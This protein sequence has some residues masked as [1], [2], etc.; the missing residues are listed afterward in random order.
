MVQDGGWN[1]VTCLSLLILWKRRPL[2]H[3]TLKES[4][5]LNTGRILTYS[6]GLNFYMT[7]TTT[8]TTFYTSAAGSTGF[9][10]CFSIS[11]SF[12]PVKLGVLTVWPIRDFK[13][14]GL[15]GASPLLMLFT[16]IACCYFT[17]GGKTSCANKN[18]KMH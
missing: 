4:P 11:N 5:L 10:L 14:S 12:T 3:V 6:P 18:K 15:C 9:H 7:T 1:P 8:M 13:G 2:L 16:L 17:E